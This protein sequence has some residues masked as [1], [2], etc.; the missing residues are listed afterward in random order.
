[1]HVVAAVL[2][3][4]LL[5]PAR[6]EACSA[7]E[8]GWQL[9]QSG[10]SLPSSAPTDGAIPVKA[11]AWEV[12][13]T[14]DLPTVE[15]KTASGEAVAGVVS[16]IVLEPGEHDEPPGR[17]DT[18]LIVWTP[19]QELAPEA[20]YSFS[21]QALHPYSGS[22]TDFTIDAE[23]TFETDATPMAALDPVSL[24]A[25]PAITEVVADQDCCSSESL[26]D[27]CNNCTTCWPTRYGYAPTINATVHL[28]DEQPQEQVY[29]EILANG[30]VRDRVWNLTEARAIAL[31]FAEDAGEP[32]CVDVVSIRL[33]E[34]SS[35]TSSEACFGQADLPSYDIREPDGSP[36]EACPAE[37]SAGCNASGT[38]HS[39][40][41]ATLLFALLLVLARR[42]TSQ[43]SST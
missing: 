37:R 4:A 1:V 7:P 26:C 13:L 23:A 42:K 40:A 33:G 24:E 11:Y 29:H 36:P 3:L 28:P 16:T 10:L 30:E 8:P 12:N 5:Y 21:I 27:S 17:P 38:P 34:G 32:Y 22:A 18:V 9:A 41:P 39:A 35:V 2:G 14:H 31:T 20:T 19:H 15:V 25:T 6:A 43:T